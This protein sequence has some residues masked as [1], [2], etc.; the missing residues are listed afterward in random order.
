[1]S[2]YGRK[3]REIRAARLAEA[4]GTPCVR[5]GQTMRPGQHL[6]LDHTDDGRSYLGFSHRGCNQRAGARKGYRG[7]L[8]AKGLN[9]GV[10]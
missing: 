5:C 1:V 3:H 4:Y 9:G 10:F 6:D 2:R 8:R 7:M